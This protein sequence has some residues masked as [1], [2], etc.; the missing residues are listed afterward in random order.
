MCYNSLRKITHLV[1]KREYLVHTYF[2]ANTSSNTFAQILASASSIKN[3]FLF[4]PLLNVILCL[5]KLV[6]MMA[7]ISKS[8][9]QIKELNSMFLT[10]TPFRC[11][12]YIPKAN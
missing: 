5:L 3:E 4:N 10:I 9:T 6:K 12:I 2:S 7:L 8:R 1:L 11:A